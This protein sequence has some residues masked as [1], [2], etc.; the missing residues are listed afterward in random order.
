MLFF[1]HFGSHKNANYL[2]FF[3][4]SS[5]TIVID[6]AKTIITNICHKFQNNLIKVTL[7]REQLESREQQLLSSVSFIFY[8]FIIIIFE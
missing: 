1:F 7:R 2:L 3:F 8:L 4:S 6:I 5:A